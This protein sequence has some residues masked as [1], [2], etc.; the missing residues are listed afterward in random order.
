MYNPK[1]LNQL[2]KTIPKA[3]VL[4]SIILISSFFFHYTS[5]SGLETTDRW[6]SRWSL[7]ICLLAVPYLAFVARQTH[8]LLL[9][10]ILP[11]AVVSLSAAF[12]KHNQSIRVLP[13]MHEGK[14]LQYFVPPSLP[15]YP[16]QTLETI[17]TI[18]IVSTALITTQKKHLKLALRV[19]GWVGF[20]NALFILYRFFSGADP[21]WRVGFVVSN[22]SMDATFVA[23]TYPIFLREKSFTS[24]KD[25]TSIAFILVQPLAV[26]AAQKWIGIGTLAI[27]IFTMAAQYVKTRP[28]RIMLFPLI[29]S[30]GMWGA[31]YFRFVNS[32]GRID[33]WEQ[34][35]SFFKENAN[36]LTGFGLGSSFQNLRLIQKLNDMDPNL[37]SYGWMHNKWLEVLFE[38]GLLGLIAIVG[39]YV[40]TLHLSFRRYPYLVP[41]VIGIGFA[42]SGN[43]LFHFSTTAIFVGAVFALIL[44]SK[45]AYKLSYE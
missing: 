30:L 25:P 3:Y 9:P 34:S 2:R 12:W 40:L 7:S 36:L 28:W 39:I 1:L 22:A 42:M 44:K 19:F 45:R 16:H 8:P 15:S 31:S 17:A 21:Y 18:L 29:G 38:Q 5:A 43:W 32:T 6:W 27:V 10:L 41:V 26:I 14:A 33:I 23:L 4:L 11:T 24:L 37:G 20:C 13:F 35:I